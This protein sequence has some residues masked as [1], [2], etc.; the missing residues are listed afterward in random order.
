MMGANVLPLPAHLT[1]S[2]HTVWRRA[3]RAMKLEIDTPSDGGPVNS[4]CGV[5]LLALSRTILVFTQSGAYP[6]DIRIYSIQLLGNFSGMLESVWRRADRVM[7]LEIDTPSDGGPVNSEC[8]V[9]LLEAK[10]L[11][12][13]RE[14]AKRFLRLR[15][16]GIQASSQ[17]PT[18][19]VRHSV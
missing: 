7:R 10:K 19:G 1:S 2:I 12:G 5:R 4:E 9:R 11:A 15:S 3:D 8:G 16:S 17:R 6:R 18:R 13:P 14:N